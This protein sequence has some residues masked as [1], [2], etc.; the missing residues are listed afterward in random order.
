[1]KYVFV[2][3]F[4][5]LTHHGKA[6]LTNEAQPEPEKTETVFT[7]GFSLANL[8][9]PVH[10]KGKKDVL[11]GQRKWK[12]SSNHI[13]TGGLVFLAGAAKGFNETLQFHWKEFRR[14]FPQANAQWFNP[15][16]SWK[17]K[18][19][20]GDPDAGAKFFGST[21]VFIMFTDQYH[22]NNFINR[23]AWGTALVIKIGEGKKP[24]KQYLLDFLYYG[25]CHQ[26]GFAATYYPFS[27]Y[28]GK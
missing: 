1:M 23:A 19:K 6:Q 20:N 3:A 18:Y 13:W 21:S 25:L 22:L 9:I 15:T 11:L 16:L 14:Q 17:N 10:D 24:F 7:P 27:K 26:A 8:N 12:I 2:L 4:A 5:I 28:K